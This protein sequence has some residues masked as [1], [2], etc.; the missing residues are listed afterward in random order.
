MRPAVLAGKGV[1]SLASV[2]WTVF[3]A[4]NRRVPSKSFQPRWAAGPLLKT[5]ERTFPQL[6]WP[7]ETD[8]LCPG[9]VKEVR[10]AVVNGEMDYRV[11][12]DGNPGEIRARIVERDGRI[13]MEKDCC[14]HG[15]FEDVMSI[16]PAF[17]RRIERLYP[18]RDFTLSPDPWP[19]HGSSTVKYGRGAVLTIDLT[20]RCNM[21]CEPCFMDANQVGYVHELTW[22]DI[23][24]LLDNS[25]EVKPRRQLSV[26]FSGGEP[27]LSPY[28]LDAVRYARKVGYISVH[29]PSN[30]LPFPHEPHFC[31]ATH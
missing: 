28:F 14:K 22:E 30:G 19:T 27:T 25:A 2:A 15:H 31:A 23:K 21:M 29:A 13:L 17:M 1:S 7:R 3:Q 12:V 6:G 20:N 26:Q 8:S 9:C 10:N 18:G 5:R 24:Q 16:D 11:L 4:V